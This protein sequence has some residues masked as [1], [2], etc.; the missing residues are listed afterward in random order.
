MS[1]RQNIPWV[2]LRPP[3]LSALPVDLREWLLLLDARLIELERENRQL[4]SEVSAL[5]YLTH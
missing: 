5:N 3:A 2:P 1:D 4:R